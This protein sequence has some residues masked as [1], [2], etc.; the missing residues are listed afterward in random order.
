MRAKAGDP[1]RT[2]PQKILA[3]RADD[4]RLDDGIVRVRVDQV[5]L[6]REP[7]ES[8]RDATERG[9]KQ[10]P[11][12]TAVA[13][14]TRCVTSGSADALAD[15]SPQRV[16]QHALERGVVIA[17][18]GIGFPA[19]VHLERFAAPARL[20]IT[21]DPRLSSMGGAGMLTLLGSRSQIAGALRDGTIM[22][23]PPRSIQILL[24][25]KL[26]PFV[27]VRDLALE[28]LRRGLHEA[29]QTIDRKHGAPVVLEFA[30]PSAR[31]LSVPE[32]ALLCSLAPRVGAV[33][34]LFVSD[35]KTEVY[36]RDQRRSKAHRALVPDA[37]APCDD[38]FPVDL[39]VIDPL[40]LDLAGNVR[41]VR[42]LEGEVVHQAV[43]GGDTGAPLRDMLA[44]AA[45]LKSKRVP[46]ELEF[47]VACASRQVLEVMA[48]SDALGDLIATGARL[49]EPDFRV[50]TAE[51]YP[52]AK[53]S[54][55]IRTYDADPGQSGGRFIVASAETL[56]YSVASGAIGDPRS[57][58]RPVRITV[59][60]LLPTDDVLVVRKPRTKGKRSE[61]AC[62]APALPE[63]RPPSWQAELPLGVVTGLTTPTEPCACL[64]GDLRELEWFAERASSLI[65]ELRVVI[66]PF[67]P[68]GWITLFS[69][70]GVLSLEADE[71]QMSA[72]QKARQVT[73]APADRWR[74]RVPLRVD[75][76]ALELGW[77]ATPEERKWAVSGGSPR[78]GQAG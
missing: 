1:P 45:L 77:G 21:D 16:A 5:V 18:A 67:V 62:A 60:R 71:S 75:G 32:R 26:R 31:L 34:A 58:K 70:C 15:T 11:V 68:S 42:E 7:N 20:A 23:R 69:A 74:E 12:E 19:A 3:A 27:C 39:S 50:L 13:Y 6:A 36:L 56:A 35:E 55:S 41:P 29:V 8:L 10:T 72:L 66:A 64:V 9:L 33:A 52:A 44:A 76:Q 40:L 61:V 2:M 38:V 48:Q 43:L 53:G 57:F 78:P 25:G 14:D 37:G 28:L 47:L 59:P 65:P 22:I 49:I 73:V 17:R 30:G 63:R 46:A 4:P 24:S 51:L 54:L